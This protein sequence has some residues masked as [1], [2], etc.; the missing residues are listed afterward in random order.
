MKMSDEVSKHRSLRTVLA[1]VVLCLLA[2]G[3]R[4][5]G[6]EARTIG[7][8][9]TLSLFRAQLSLPEL[10]SNRV[11]PPGLNVADPHPPLYYLLLAAFTRPAGKSDFALRILSAAWS[12][13]LVPLLYAAGTR[14]WN[15]RA[16]VIAALLGTLSP[17]YLWYAQEARM[18]IMV[19]ALGLFA[20]YALDR[21]L[22]ERHAAWLAAS[23]LGAA[24]AAC[25]SYPA[26][27][28]LPVLGLQV[29][30]AG[31]LRGAWRRGI[32]LGLAGLALA[33]LLALGYGLWHS[34]SSPGVGAWA[35]LLRDALHSL[36]AGQT[37]AWQS[38]WPV[39][40]IWL[41]LLFLGLLWPGQGRRWALLAGY[42][43]IP[44]LAS[45]AALW[46]GPGELKPPQA[47]LVEP[48]YGGAGHLLLLSPAF[49]LGVA[50]G[51]ER[52]SSTRYWPAALVAGLTLLAN[53]G[54][55]TGSYFRALPPHTSQDYHAAARAIQRYER[56]RDVIV[57]TGPESITALMHY[58][59]GS[60][61]AIALRPTTGD[62]PDRAAAR[63]IIA[64]LTARFERIWLVQTRLSDPERQAE[65]WL[66]QHAFLAESTIYPGHDVDA[67]LQL[68][69]TRAP[70]LEEPPSPQH[71]VQVDF[72][73][74][75]LEGY[76]L[77]LQPITGGERAWV[78]LYWQTLEPADVGVSLRLVDEQR[79]TW[80]R[81]DQVPYPTFPPQRWPVG[82]L[83]RHEASLLVPPGV[84][85][86]WYTLEIRLYDPAIGRPIEPLSG[87]RPGPLHLGPVRIEATWLKHAYLRSLSEAQHT[88][89]AGRMRFGDNIALRAYRLPTEGVRP[90]EWLPV[91]L[92]WEVERSPEHNLT[93]WLEL[94]DG[95]GAVVSSQAMW[96]AGARY[97]PTLWRA[98][99][100]L[101]GQ[102]QLLVPTTAQPGVYRLRLSMHDEAGRPMP[103]RDQ[104]RFWTWGQNAASLSPVRVLRVSR[105]FAMPRM[106]RTLAAR[107]TVGIDLLG[108]D[109]TLQ[110]VRAGEALDVTLHWRAAAVPSESY[111]VSIQLLTA[112]E[113]TILA[114]EDSVPAG[115]SRPTTGWSLG[116][117]VADPHRVPVP[118]SVTP[119]NAVLIVALYDEDTGRRVQWVEGSQT[120]EHTVLSTVEIAN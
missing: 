84:P 23:L 93:L 59:Q 94:V 46:H 17:L 77:P 32:L 64:D 34:Q 38:A 57:T 99:D 20:V 90:G 68:Y 10:L 81:V 12:L 117:I 88:L 16:G 51:L 44:L 42:I 21:S 63:Q 27:A 52:A 112:D 74:L 45:Y 31:R 103:V 107:S 70:Q 101:W 120:H 47:S 58:Y 102:Y 65:A 86:G 7:Y 40:L 39:S 98:Q 50:R 53:T 111:K 97:A 1:V 48:G 80:G 66:A 56:P 73:G 13:L 69:L 87:A 118:A 82:A 91:D 3:V 22:E 8:D 5:W 11:E 119:Q 30:A 54:A 28:L 55:S 104:W 14:F 72:G 96:P 61:P 114:Q 62:A 18:Y 43:A 95:Q 2:F 4:T 115:W 60:A 85:P 100:L 35:A 9:E 78:T 89:L 75:R 106:D 49:Y 79:R 109:G 15:R 105:D 33:G 92:Y 108:F 83:M 26:L 24:M 41:G 6:L 36:G 19:A 116:E 25:T 76:D 113:R 67:Q 71:T 29:L 37:L 110:R